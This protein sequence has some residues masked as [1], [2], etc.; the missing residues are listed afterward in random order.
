MFSPVLQDQFVRLK[1][2]YGG[3]TLEALPSG[4]ALV[5]IPDFPLPAG[6]TANATQVRFLVPVGYPGPF[7]DCFWAT[8]GLRL[9]NG[10]LPTNANDPN[11]IPETGHQDLWFSWHI[12]DAAQNWNPSRDD[13]MTYVSIIALR[14]ERLQ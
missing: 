11:P 5:T 2:R 7:P 13:L 12:V 3:A 1:T 8:S 9:A 6:W 10:Q 14:F 4:A